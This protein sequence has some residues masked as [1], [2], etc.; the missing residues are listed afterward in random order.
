MQKYP[1][2]IAVAILFLGSANS[3]VAED[4]DGLKPLIGV[5]G[6]VIEIRPYKIADDVDPDTLGL[7]RKFLIDFA[8]KRLRPSKDSLVRKTVEFSEVAHIE[9]K[10][11]IQ[12]VDEGIEGVN[13]GWAWN[14]IISKKDG[15]AVLSASGDG[16][17]YVVFGVCTPIRDNP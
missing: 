13:D 3:A 11:V 2:L 8:A 9:D 17:A 15:K 14:L 10:I 4:F 16:V 5:T 6:K 12:G 1:F 7:P